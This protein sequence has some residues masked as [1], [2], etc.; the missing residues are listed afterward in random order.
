MM[1]EDIKHR[2]EVDHALGDR[3]YRRWAGREMKAGRLVAF[4]VETCNDRPAAGGVVWLRQVQPSPRYAG[5]RL[6][7]LMSMYT[8]PEFRGKGFATR[9]VKDAERWARSNGY[10]WM[11]LHASETGRL[12]YE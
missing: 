4:L 8:E 11:T 5:G 2:T 9:V 12:L 6:P 3:S 7:Y 10:P 1:F